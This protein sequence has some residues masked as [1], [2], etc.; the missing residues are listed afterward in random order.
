MYGNF[1]HQ[2]NFKGSDFELN[3]LTNFPVFLSDKCSGVKLKSAGTVTDKG[4]KNKVT[5]RASF[6]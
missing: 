3:N 6:N 2:N 1:P 4:T 5:V